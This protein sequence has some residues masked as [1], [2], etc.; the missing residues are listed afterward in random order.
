MELKI[1]IDETKFKEVIE[2]E[3]D[4]FDKEELKEIIREGLIKCISEPKSFE[5]LFVREYNSWNNSYKDATDILRD[6]AKTVNLSP[7]FDEF[8]QKARQWLTDNHS[9]VIQL[10]TDML[11]QGLTQ[12]LLSSDFTNNIRDRLMYELYKQKNQ[13]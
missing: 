12:R 6:A 5:G 7:V 4:A 10:F 11:M 9:N 8:E 2:Q 1:I 3:L 13:N